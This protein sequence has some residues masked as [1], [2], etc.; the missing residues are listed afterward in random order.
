MIH[1]YTRE[2]HENK[3]KRLWATYDLHETVAVLI[4]SR[5]L[6]VSVAYVS[7]LCESKIAVFILKYELNFN[8]KE[9]NCSYFNENVGFL[10]FY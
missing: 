4:N 2:C 9:Y 6:K 10:L 8:V 7:L 1:V 3:S 5:S